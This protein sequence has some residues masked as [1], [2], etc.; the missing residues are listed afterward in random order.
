MQKERK[1]FIRENAAA[2]E[3]SESTG[4]IPHHFR[5]MKELTVLGYFTSEIGS[6]RCPR[7]G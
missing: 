6:V 5:V 4:E 2:Q 3:S 1:K 7:L